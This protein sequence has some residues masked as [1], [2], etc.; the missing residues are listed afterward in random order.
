MSWHDNAQ[1]GKKKEID[2]AKKEVTQATNCDNVIELK[3]DF[4]IKMSTRILL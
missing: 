2:Q 3:M 1:D 4:S